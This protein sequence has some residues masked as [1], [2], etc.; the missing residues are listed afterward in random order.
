MPVHLG[1]GVHPLVS[2]P[3]AGPGH[4]PRV[5]EVVLADHPGQVQGELQFRLDGLCA[6]VSVQ[7]TGETIR[8]N[9]YPSRR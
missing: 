6:L 5:S 2:A 8:K 7:S 1:D 3:S 4:L 9:R